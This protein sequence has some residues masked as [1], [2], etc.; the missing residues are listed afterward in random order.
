[1]I[2]RAF[3]QEANTFLFGEPTSN[4]DIQHQLEVMEIIK[5]SWQRRTSQRSFILIIIKNRVLLGY[6]SYIPNK[7]KWDSHVTRSS[8]DHCHWC[9]F[10]SIRSHTLDM[11]RGLMDLDIG[12]K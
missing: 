5:T 12:R 8:S 1:M 3:A 9:R 11:N 7:V 6:I 2:A 10:R 4:L